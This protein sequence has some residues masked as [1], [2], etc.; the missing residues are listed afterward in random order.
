MNIWGLERKDKKAKESIKSLKDE[1]NKNSRNAYVLADRD[2]LKSLKAKLRQAYEEDKPKL[3]KEM[4]YLEKRL[5][6]IDYKLVFLL[7]KIEIEEKVRLSCKR[8]IEELRQK[9]RKNK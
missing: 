8:R 1:I 7:N 3:E 4:V 2:K 6:K 5:E 9:R